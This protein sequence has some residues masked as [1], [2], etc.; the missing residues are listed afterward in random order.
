[1]YQG[2]PITSKFLQ[3]TTVLNLKRQLREE[4]KSNKS[5]QNEINQLKETIK[6]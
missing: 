5:L 6:S 1:M 4:R 3:Q 2:K